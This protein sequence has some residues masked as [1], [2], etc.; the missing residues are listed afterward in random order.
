MDAQVM[1]FDEGRVTSAAAKL[2]TAIGTG[3]K[4]ARVREGY[5][6]VRGRLSN[7]T[8]VFVVGAGDYADVATR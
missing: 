7:V 3:G 2:L 5:E 6:V 1:C 8:C 4:Y